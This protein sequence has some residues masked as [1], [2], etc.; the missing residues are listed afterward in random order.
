M[1]S[2]I[3]DNRSDPQHAQDV[4]PGTTTR[5]RGRWSGK[6]LRAGLR[7]T[8]PFTSVV[9]A[10][11]FSAASSSLGG[12]RRELVQ[13]KLKLIEKDAPCARTESHRASDG[14]SRS[15]ASRRRPGLP[16]LTPSPRP[17]PP[18]PRTPRVQPSAPQCRANRRRPWSAANHRRR[19]PAIPNRVRP[20]QPWSGEAQPAR[21]GRQVRTGLRQSIPSNK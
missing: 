13:G 21:N 11:A 9:R 20:P 19:L 2:P 7:R 12:A 14:A 8:N 4:G 3:F 16:R 15:S 5:S 10:A 18:V 6:G 17:P 1:S